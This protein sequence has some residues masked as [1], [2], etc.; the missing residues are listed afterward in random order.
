MGVL[1]AKRP[2]RGGARI[3]A[4]ALDYLLFTLYLTAT[5][6]VG[7]ALTLGPLGEAWQ[8]ALRVPW[9]MHLLAFATTVLPL[10]LYFAVT[11]SGQHGASWGKRR[12]GLRVEALDG[13]QASF[14]RS[15]LRNAVKFLPW[16]LAHTAML[17]IPGFPMQV[18]A[19][20]TW[21]VVALCA[22]WIVV[23]VYLVG[24]TRW[25]GSRPLYDRIAGTRVVAARPPDPA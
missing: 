7:I 14:G 23:G 4:F 1:G 20:P 15:L 18:R 13:A 10:T 21:T 11:E 8:A 2:G 6:A 17:A 12:R 9:R 5:A 3:V 19:V 22:V 16:H 24:L 25:A